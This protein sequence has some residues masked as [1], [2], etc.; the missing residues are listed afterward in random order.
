MKAHFQV[1]NFNGGAPVEVIEMDDALLAPEA[2]IV[3]PATMTLR[4]IKN[5]GMFSLI[6]VDDHTVATLLRVREEY[7]LVTE[8]PAKRFTTHLSRID[9]L[10]E[11]IGLLFGEIEY[12]LVENKDDIDKIINPKHDHEHKK[13]KYSILGDLL[14]NAVDKTGH[15][16]GP[17]CTHG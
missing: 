8:T 17:D 9:S 7:K 5:G 10:I 6:P 15:K 13:V 4:P 16:C 2:G 14:K 12:V 3:D 11:T 1:F